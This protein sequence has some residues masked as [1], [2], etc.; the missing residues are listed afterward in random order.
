MEQHDIENSINQINQFILDYLY[1]YAQHMSNIVQRLPTSRTIRKN[2]KDVNTEIKNYNQICDELKIF[3]VH[4]IKLPFLVQ[5]KTYAKI[6]NNIQSSLIKLHDYG[7][8][9]C[10]AKHLIY[11]YII[12]PML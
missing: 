7:L 5:H 6:E 1:M 8:T 12:T 4:I 10:A 11:D 9:V 2:I 3:G